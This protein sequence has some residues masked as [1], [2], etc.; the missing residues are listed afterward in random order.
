MENGVIEKTRRWIS[1]IVIGLNLCPFA[2]R[3]FDGEK[4]RYFVSQAMSEES[5]L[6]DLKT[7]LE[8]LNTTA[9][10]EIETT[11]V[12]HPQVLIGFFEYNDFLEV[13]NALVENL[14][15]SGEIQIA[16]FHP[17][18]Q[19]AGTTPDAVENYTNRSPYPM[20]H[21]LREDSITNLK[22]APEE[23]LQ[24]PERNVA[25]LTKMGIAEVRKLIPD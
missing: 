17:Q 20:L 14:S 1:D 3:V 12:I 11:I 2:R 22:I 5:L 21:L 16:S 4:I 9:I 18:Y 6:I 25:L 8:R 23:L 19:F 13:A 10:S 7:E 24:I 15:L